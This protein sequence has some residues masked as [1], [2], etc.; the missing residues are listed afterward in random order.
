MAKPFLL[1]I[2]WFFLNVARKPFHFQYKIFLKDCQQL[3]KNE[4]PVLKLPIIKH[5][6]LIFPKNFKV[7]DGLSLITKFQKR[8]YFFKQLLTIFLENNI[9]TDYNLRTVNQK[10]FCRSY[11]TLEWL[12]T[13]KKH[14]IFT[15]KMFVFCSSVYSLMVQIRLMK[16]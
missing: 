9:F 12:E 3:L 1:N 13:R 10:K 14:I 15:L 16:V 8:L 2:S 5:K 4:K 6:I 11:L 7:N